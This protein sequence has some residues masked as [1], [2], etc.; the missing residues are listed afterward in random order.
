[1]Y[2]YV[3]SRARVLYWIYMTEPEGREARGRGHI[4]PIQRECTW[5]NEFMFQWSHTFGIAV[6]AQYVPRE[7]AGQ[8]AG[9]CAAVASAAGQVCYADMEAKY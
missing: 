1:M 5:Y 4:N 2:V 7:H 6:H 9:V 8:V 3:I